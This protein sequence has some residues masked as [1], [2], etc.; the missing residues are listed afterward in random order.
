VN[1]R[2]AIGVAAALA[3]AFAST[4]AAANP[5]AAKKIAFGQYLSGECVT[6]H[7][8]SGAAKGIPP[9]VAWPED[10][11]VAVMQSYKTKVRDNVAMQTIAGRLSDEEIYALAAYFGSLKSAQ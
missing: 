3:A 4:V 8:L 7:Q 1:V 6:C 10:G 11:F 9:I 5:E 2:R